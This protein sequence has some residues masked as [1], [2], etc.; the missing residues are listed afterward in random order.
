MQLIVPV[1]F[2][3]VPLPEKVEM[4]KVFPGVMGV[5]GFDEPLVPAELV[6]VTVNAYA[7]PPVRPVTMQKRAPVV[8]HVRPSGLDVTVYPVIAPPELE[9]AVQET[10]L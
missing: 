5:D 6:A 4:V 1:L 8:V 10:T 9:A 3:T 2:V 7:T